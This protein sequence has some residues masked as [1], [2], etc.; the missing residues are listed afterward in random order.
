MI[1]EIQEIMKQKFWG[2]SLLDY[3]VAFLIF[4]ASLVAIKLFK[5]IFLKHLKKWA[6]KTSTTIDDFLIGITEK[7]IIPLLC[8]GA[9]YLSINTL[10][11][12]PIL[13]KIVDVAGL[14]VLTIYTVRLVTV[15]I[16][17]GFEV[18]LSKRGK[19]T[20]LKRSLDGILRI[21]KVVIWGL[22]IVFFLDNLG[23]RISAVIAGLGIGGIAVAMAAQAVLKDLFSYF[24]II[25]DRPFELGDF[26]IIGEYLGTV[27]YIGI[28]TTRIRSL[29]GE[30]LVF[31]NTD[32]TDSRVRNYKRMAKRRVSFRF[33]VTYQTPLDKLKEI[34]KIVENIIKN[35]DDTIFDRTHFV[36]YGD[37]SLIFEVVYYILGSD[38]NKYMDIQQKINLGIKEEFEKLN[39]E[40]AYP[41]QTIYLNKSNE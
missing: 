12:T 8:F 40:F 32:L 18:Y 30:Q 2:N 20:V 36:S 13:K 33:G 3:M 11:L 14:A 29:S 23:F 1:Q 7:I 19:D 10:I 21:T 34:P 37:F 24:C 28:K 5:N 31:S 4:L 39:V 25:F 9:F 27:E 15:S 6:E 16:S 41:T 17:Y 35:I 22:A 38:Y 26:I